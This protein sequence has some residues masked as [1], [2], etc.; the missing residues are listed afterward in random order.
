MGR[1]RRLAA[2]ERRARRNGRQMIDIIDITGQPRRV[3]IGL[4]S[5]EERARLMAGI[6]A[7]LERVAGQGHETG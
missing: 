1:Q 7:K 3:S 6:L 5:P 2:L 4:P